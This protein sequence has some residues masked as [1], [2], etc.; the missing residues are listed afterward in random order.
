MNRFHTQYRELT[1]EEKDLIKQIKDTATSL[2]EL[3]Q[4][5]HK[6]DSPTLGPTR[7]ISIALTKL[8]ESVMWAVK[9]ITK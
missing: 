1:P 8:E 3:Y 5:S 6:P 9:S 2:E 4:L 7:Q